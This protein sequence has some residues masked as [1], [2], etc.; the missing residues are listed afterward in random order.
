M[1]TTA[2]R[3]R[4][5]W[6]ARPLA[7]GAHR[8]AAQGTGEPLDGWPCQAASRAGCA[9]RW[10]CELHTA[11]RADAWRVVSGCTREGDARGPGVA[12]HGRAPGGCV[13]HR[14][15][16]GATTAPGERKG[17]A[18][19]ARA[20][21][22]AGSRRARLAAA[23]QRARRGAAA[24]ARAE[25]GARG[26][27]GSRWA[28]QAVAAQRARRGAAPGHRAL[29]GWATTPAGCGLEQA[30]ARGMGTTA[31]QSNHD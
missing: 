19:R 10:P 15:T 22:G 11:G 31:T 14:A 25:E 17:A 2:T 29:A 8:A 9:P 13:G 27:A 20:G 12:R 3:P 16:R 7:H 26:G 23:A 6:P 30:G 24:H 28:G 4:W 21:E 5:P 18:P 1:K